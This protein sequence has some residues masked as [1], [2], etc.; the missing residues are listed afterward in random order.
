[1]YNREVRVALEIILKL[2]NKLDTPSVADL[3]VIFKFIHQPGGE[4][5]NIYTALVKLNS[6]WAIYFTLRKCTKL[7]H[8]QLIIKG[9]NQNIKSYV[10]LIRR[11][12]HTLIEPL[13]TKGGKLKSC[14]IGKP[15][16][17]ACWEL[18]REYETCNTFPPSV[19]NFS[20]LCITLLFIMRF[21]FTLQRK[22]K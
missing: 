3:N 1:M 7:I 21:V 4:N 18:Q 16:V 17:S 12:V 2:I 9:C 10:C 20:H 19:I 5:L 11:G 13:C 8:N 6:N 22:R 15:Q 14:V